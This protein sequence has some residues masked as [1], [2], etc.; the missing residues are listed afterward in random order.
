MMF[1]MIAD[2]TII[3]QLQS[4]LEIALRVSNVYYSHKI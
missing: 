2:L 1:S 3:I 4:R